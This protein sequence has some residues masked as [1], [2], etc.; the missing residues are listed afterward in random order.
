MRGSCNK[1]L[2]ALRE[3]RRACRGKDQEIVVIDAIQTMFIKNTVAGG[4]AGFLALFSR[5]HHGQIPYPNRSNVQS[6]DRVISR[7]M[8]IVQTAEVG[9][10]RQQVR[11]GTTHLEFT[12]IVEKGGFRTHMRK[13]R[14]G[15][16]IGPHRKGQLTPM[17]PTNATHPPT[18]HATV[19]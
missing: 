16:R 5:G 1:R 14:S 19:R 2:G 12:M 6:Q 8:V 13:K 11:Q 10:V 7:S 15:A 17:N 4:S 3:V 9:C 18:P